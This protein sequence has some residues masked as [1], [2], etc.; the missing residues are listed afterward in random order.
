MIKK[1]QEHGITNA[2]IFKIEKLQQHVETAAD[3]SKGLISYL[4]ELN[5]SLNKITD[6]DDL[7]RYAF[8]IFAELGGLVYPNAGAAIHY[9]LKI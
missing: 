9:F 6:N 2:V 5:N 4:T 7:K 8:Q 1:F 3:F